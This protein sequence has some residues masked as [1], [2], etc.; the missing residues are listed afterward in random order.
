MSAIITDQIRIL[1]SKSFIDSIKTGKSNLYTFIGLPNS[2]E[3]SV[4]WDSN[5]PSPKDSFNDENDYW[6]TMISLKKVNPDSDIR[7]V[8]RKVVWDSGSSYDMYRHDITRNN[9]SIP[10][11]KTSL[12]QSNYYIL[13]KDYRVYI[14]LNNGATQENSFEALPSLVEPTF[15]DLEPKLLEDGYTWKYLYT[16][17][18]EDVIKFDSLNFIPVPSDWTTA[19]EYQAIRL[20]AQTSGQIKVATITDAGENLGRSKVYSNLSILGDGTGGE[21]SIVVG[22]EQKVISVFVTKGGSGYTYGTID[23]STISFPENSTPPQFNVIIPPKGGHGFDIYNELGAYNVLIYSR[24][25]N[26]TT[27]PDFI[28]GN[29]IARIGIVN[30]PLAFGSTIILNR[31]RASATYALKL[32]GTTNR[33]DYVGA[34]II[35]D[36][37]F[38]QTIG[39]GVTAVG[40][41]ISYDNRTGILKYWQDKSLYGFNLNGEFN[42]NGSVKPKNIPQYGYKKIPFSASVGASGSININGLPVSLK[43]DTAFTGITTVINNVTYNLGQTFTSGVSNPEVKPKSGDIIYVDNRPSITRSPEQREDVKVI[44]QF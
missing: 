17:K 16:L 35:P 40:R 36:S 39:A 4:D 44:L 14:C 12:Y 7:N 23:L 3:Y 37:T 11:Q 9:L 34:N 18:V 27:N 29:Q 8:I 15:I 41:V 38:T 19:A 20:N 25:E 30:N 33:N 43:I 42:E 24:F 21:V 22:N 13:T 2:S 1:N 6:D 26:D 31:D 32:V 28:T 10:S 5:P